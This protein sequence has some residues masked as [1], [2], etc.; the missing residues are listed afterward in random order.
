MYYRQL[1]EKYRNAYS[2]LLQ[3]YP[4][5]YYDR[6]NEGMQ[7]TFSDLL[8]ERA[9]KGRN[10]LTCCTWVFIETCLGIIRENIKFIIM[11]NKNIVRIALVTLAI[12][13]IPLVAMQFN[14]D[15]V[16]TLSD[17]IFAGAVIFVTGLLYEL[18]ARQSKNIT[19]RAAFALALGTG[20]LLLWINAAVGIVGSGANLPNILYMALLAIG[21]LGAI[22]AR[23]RPQGLSRLLFLMA[24]LQA[25]IAVIALVIEGGREWLQIVALNGF[26]IVMWAA[27]ALLFQQAGEKNQTTLI[28]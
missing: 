23:F 3:F 24:G 28:K 10:L 12:L 25:I 9:G 20:F 22:I 18:V 8:N 11:R 2:K 16:W 1:I 6:F 13:M 4:A 15:M 19:Y 21:F 27:A 17:F 26:F 7:Q 5:A 14:K